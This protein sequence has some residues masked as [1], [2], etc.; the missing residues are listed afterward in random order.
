MEK[1]GALLNSVYKP[2]NAGTYQQSE[3]D[4]KPPVSVKEEF[5]D[6]DNQYAKIKVRSRFDMFVRYP[7]AAKR[8]KETFCYRGDHYEKNPERQLWSLVRFFIN[9]HTQ[10]L[11]AELY[12]NTI[13][14]TEDER[15]VLIYKRNK[16]LERN[17]L[18]KYWP[19]LQNDPVPDWLKPY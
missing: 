15:K 5:E 18:S 4:K 19:M 11:V 13:P 14:K 8:Q 16:G 3:S 10:W 17:F 6:L 9:N 7:K 2:E 12:D 1:I